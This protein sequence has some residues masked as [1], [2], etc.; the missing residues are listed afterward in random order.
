MKFENK[1]DILWPRKV[2]IWDVWVNAAWAFISG[3]IWSVLLL[4]LIFWVSW[5]IDVWW[6]F[7]KTWLSHANEISMTFPFLLSIITFFVSIIVMFITYFFLTKTDPNKFW[8]TQI[9]KWQIA[10]FAIITY[11][12]IT[13]V[14]IYTWMLDVENIIYVFMVHI[15]ILFFWLSIILEI[16][17]NFR[18]I[19]VWLYGTF[20]WIFLTWIIII[21]IFLNL[22]SWYAKLLS[23]LAIL[24]LINWLIIFFKWLFELLYYKYYS[25]TWMDQ[26][27]DIIR[28]VE[29]E[30]NEQ[31]Q[32]AVEENSNY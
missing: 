30:E 32:M 4:V 21:A 1:E 17:N 25:M 26:L 19:L 29:L 6:A 8:E 18:Y 7:K 12:F 23:L 11:I 13:P 2:S 16:L 22:D 31:Y 24:P 27:W 15:F 9:H 5:I 28:Q 3:I 10:F 14:Y 20:I